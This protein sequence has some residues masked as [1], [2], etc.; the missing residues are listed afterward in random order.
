MAT[1]KDGGRRKADMS[2]SGASAPRPAAK[3][4][5]VLSPLRTNSIQRFAMKRDEA[6]AAL[7]ISPST[8]D[9]WVRKGLMPSGVR[10]EGLRLWD[11]GQ[12]H[13]AWQNILE[14]TDVDA[15][16]DGQNPFDGVV[17]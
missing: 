9:A 10:V 14:A 8:F 3:R 15:S 7:G 13:G 1:S 4:K 16:D 17:V 12:V 2:T 6:A 5:G 11:T